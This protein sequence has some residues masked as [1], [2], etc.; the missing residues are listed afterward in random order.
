MTQRILRT[1]PRVLS[2]AFVV[3]CLSAPLAAQSSQGSILGEVKDAT[4]ASVPGATI[5]L[6]NTD[7]G[8]TRTTVSS[9]SGEYQFL[10]VKNSHYSLQVTAP[11]FKT[12]VIS[13]LE[14][15]ARQQLR[16]DVSLTIGAVQQEVA[17]S[18][19][20]TSSIE[21]DTSTISAVLNVDDV[22]NLPI[23]SRAG[24]AGTSGLNLIGTLP[25]VQSDPGGFSLQGGLPFQTEV[26]VD[27]VTIQS[28]TGNSPIAD[29]FPSTEAIQ[30]IRAD[31]VGNNAEFGQPGAVTTVTKSGTNKIHGSAFWYY[32]AD[33]LDAIPFGADRKPHI[34]GNT[35]GGSFGGPVVIPHLYNGHDKTFVFGDYEGYR[36]PSQVA[37]QYVV[38]TAAMKAGDFT[39]YQ[40][41][42]KNGNN[43]FTGLTNP[44]TGANIGYKLPAVNAIAAKFLPFYP[45][46]NH[47]NTT[48]YVDGQGPNYYVNQDASKHSDQFD[49]RGD[50]YF[51]TNQKLLIWARYTWKDFPSASPEPL[52][53]PSATDVNNYRVLNTSVNYAVKA[54]LID[55]FRFGYTLATNGQTDSYNGTTFTNG[56]GLVGLQNLFYNGLPELD[57]NNLSSFNADRLSSLSNS[58]TYVY[59]DSLIWNKGSHTLKFGV[60]IRSIE[61]KTP[62]GFNGSDNYGTFQFNTSGSTGLFT[63][64]DFADFLSGIPNSTFYDVVAQDNDGKT[65]H[66]HAYAQD[67]WKANKQ[68]TLTYGVRYELHPGYSDP[69]GDIGNFDPSHP[70]SG[71]SIYPDGKASLLSTAFLASANA[72]SPYGSTSGGA[73]VNGAPCM[74]VLSNSQ[75]GYGTG[76]KKVPHL[77][78]MPRFGFAYRPLDTSKTTIRGG[79]GLYNITVLGS[80]FYSLTGTLQADTVQYANTYNP[81]TH[82][83]GYAWPTIYAGAG[84]DSN[85][86]GYGQDYFGTANDTKWKDPYTIQYSL[87]V[88]HDFGRGYA[89]RVSYIGSGNRDLVWAP[90]ENTLPFSSTVSAANQ[91]LSARLFPNWGRI[92]D[93]STGANESYNSLQVEASHRFQRGFQFDSAWT[94][95]KALA[96]N[97]GPT[98][99]GFAGENGGSRS[100]SILDRHADFGNTYGTRRHRWNTT[101]IYD[102]PV[103]R[104][105]QFAGNVPRAADLLIGGWRLTSILL[106]QTGDFLTPYFPAGQG[107]PSGTGSGLTTTNTGFDPGHRT[108]HSDTISKNYK[109]ANQNRTLWVNPAAFTCPGSTTWTVGQKCTTGAGGAG[110]APPI[111]RF[112][113]TEVGSVVGPGMVNL[114]TGLSKSFHVTE[115][116]RLK[117]EG[118]FTNVLNHTNLGDPNLNLSSSSFG[119]ITNAI[120][121]NSTGYDQAGNRTGQVSMRLEF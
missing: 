83:I 71:A 74:P 45:D 16:E 57:F 3:S 54:N 58:N 62:L 21:T 116:V 61:A 6:K 5:L 17:V 53:V 39:N 32:Q 105:K 14:L 108:Q 56:L 4:G 78:F 13:G 23:N 20:T 26:Q 19:E 2:V 79:V 69:N 10:D 59:T 81:T 28:A 121:Y 50:Q 47:G 72:C 18:G 118:T 31:G 92:N 111:G 115:G 97:Q 49:I 1:I 22:E 35:F 42:D 7:E 95:A 68:L 80:S 96:D 43:T 106:L 117:A 70:L 24:I 11:G 67:E 119:Q 30:E 40:V 113:N 103:G 73:T 44:A 41:L 84:S 66:Y 77:R 34:V 46:P 76:L 114:S 15:T 100:S 94:Y 86:V 87:D 93:R 104:G 52:L 82:A 63:G 91:P 60:D 25:G 51:G 27:G 48:T 90:D 55:E 64:V 33:A 88:D 36:F 12:F 75:A 65:H 8:A 37:N 98:N 110:D 38:P 109:P 85:S 107:D 29:A 9:A 99:T 112:G 120:G 101:M 102:L 89:V